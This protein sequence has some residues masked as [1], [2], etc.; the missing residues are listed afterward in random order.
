MRDWWWLWSRC[1]GLGSRRMRMLETSAK[2][3]GLGLDDLWACTPERLHQILPWS[4]ALLTRI[5][6][7]R[8]ACGTRPD[9]T[10]PD[11]ALLPLDNAWPTSLDALAQP[12]LALFHRG[13]LKLLQ[14]LSPCKA[15]AVVGTRAASSHGLRIAE[16]LGRVLAGAG[17]PVIS[18][19]AEGIDGAAH[20]GCLQAGGAPVA[21]LGTPLDRSYPRHHDMLQAEIGGSGLLLTELPPGT[22]VQRGHFAARNRLVAAFAR[23]VVVVECPERSGAL[24]TA[25][26][27]AERHCPV[28]AIPG[29]ARRWSARGSNALMLGQATPLL[30]P[31]ALV[32]QL[33]QGPLKAGVQLPDTAKIRPSSPD[34]TALLKAVGDGATLQELCSRLGRSS[35]VL[36]LT[37]LELELAGRVLCESGNRWRALHG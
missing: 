10:V 1:P 13:K 37:L 18:G 5:E 12:P 36:A 23:A 21:V 35:D 8:Q 19:L 29:D 16:D 26:L 9:R 20:R 4:D 11:N 17:W 3:H 25:R 24:I 6:S 33:E 2:A 32:N 15:V 14:C 31:E 28:W 34:Q 22:T 27:A 30:S 7:Y